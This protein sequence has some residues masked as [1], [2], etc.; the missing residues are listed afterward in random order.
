MKYY[1]GDEFTIN[2]EEL[3]PD[4]I[5]QMQELGIE[6]QTIDIRSQL[7]QSINAKIC[8]EVFTMYDMSVYNENITLFLEDDTNNMIGFLMFNI[9]IDKSSIE[10]LFLC[11]KKK[12]SGKILLDKIKEFAKIMKIP[13]VEL[14]VAMVMN[15]TTYEVDMVATDKL[16]SYYAT[17]NFKVGK[18]PS[19]MVYTVDSKK[20]PSKKSTSK[21]SA[22]SSKGKTPKGK[23][24][25]TAV[26]KGGNIINRTRKSK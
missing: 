23:K 21:D 6:P 11:S 2:R 12:G 25:K 15:P 5:K 13:I 16:I 24:G 26:K 10:I 8:K 20:S 9:P 18:K 19:I 17:N 22:S 7:K 3:L 4:I 14:E 1:I